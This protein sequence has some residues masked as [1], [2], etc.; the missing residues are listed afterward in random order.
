MVGAPYVFRH[1]YLVNESNTVQWWKSGPKEE[2]EGILE[3][4]QGGGGKTRKKQN[5]KKLWIKQARAKDGSKTRSW[6][7]I[8]IGKMREANDDYEV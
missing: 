4:T 1:L 3:G 5:I 7:A 6:T 2:F 8:G